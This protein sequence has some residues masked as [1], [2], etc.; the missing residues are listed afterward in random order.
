MS[1]QWQYAS[2]VCNVCSA[3]SCRD[4][5]PRTTWPLSLFPDCLITSY[6]SQWHVHPLPSIPSAWSS[7]LSYIFICYQISSEHYLFTLFHCTSPLS[8]PPP[9][10][11]ILSY[12]VSLSRSCRHH[13]MLFTP[14]SLFHPVTSSLFF[15]PTL[16]SVS[17]EPL[18][19]HRYTDCRLCRGGGMLLR[20]SSWR[21]CTVQLPLCLWT[22]HLVQ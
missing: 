6:K 10:F 16:F 12:S 3:I 19:L 13:L 9:W 20:H 21:Y 15:S 1:N 7:P 14:R 18:R 8:T 4:L 5:S 2:A 17:V 11:P 22:P